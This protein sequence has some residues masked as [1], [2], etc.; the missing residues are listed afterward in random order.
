MDSSHKDLFEKI[1][2]K[3]FKSSIEPQL[4][5]SSIN[6][7]VIEITA[8]EIRQLIGLS[9]ILSSSNDKEDLKSAYE[10]ITR[11]IEISFEENRELYA[12][13]DIILARLGN[14]PGRT[15]LRNRY[16]L[17]SKPKISTWLK[18]E[19]LAREVENSIDDNE[20]ILT[21]F[22]YELYHAL[23]EEKS[24]SVS[25]PTSAG[26]SYILNLDLVRR[27]KRKGNQCIIYIVP[28]RALIT[29]VSLRIRKSLTSAQLTG[30]IVRT[31][32]FPVDMKQIENSV[33]YVLTQERL[34][35]LINTNSDNFTIDSLIVD[36]AHE[37]QKGKR[38]IVLQNAVDSV[39]NKFSSCSVLFA[40]PLIKNPSYFLDLFKRNESG[41][42][43][44]EELSPVSQNILLL[45][46]VPKKTQ[47]VK[48]EQLCDNQI[49]Q[50]GIRE[51]DFKFRGT[52]A[53]QHAEIAHSISNSTES[54]IIFANGPKKAED[55]AEHLTEIISFQGYDNA[56]KEFI[57]FLSSE[58][59]AEYPL[60]KCLKK[61][62]AFHYG[63]MPSI[64]RKGIEDLFKSGS[65]NY[66]CCTSTLL[67]GVNL[68]AKHIIIE[69]PHN[70]DT[71]M[72][73]ADFLNLAG[74]AGRLLEEFHGNIWCV[75]PSNWAEESYKGEK[76]SEIT[77]AMSV[78][79]EDGGSDI[80]DLLSNQLTD[81]GR[82]EN[83]E[84]AFAKLYNDY[85][86]G[87][88][89]T[90]KQP[91]ITDY[92][93]ENLNITLGLC[94][95]THINV[96]SEIL[97]AHR[98]LRPDHIQ[99]LLDNLA[100]RSS[101]EPLIPINPRV[102]G[103]KIIIEDIISIIND[104]FEWGIHDNYKPLLSYVAYNWVWEMPISKLMA[105]RVEFIRERDPDVSLSG[106]FRSTLKIIEKDI[107]FNLVKY[108]SVY[109]DVLK[110]LLAIN[111]KGELVDS[112]EP[113]HIY[114][115]FGSCSKVALNLMAIGLSRF[116]ALNLSR[117]FGFLFE[118]DVE[119]E[120]YLEELKVVDLDKARM[121][122][123]CIEE[124]KELVRYHY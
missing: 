114:F 45:S 92:D 97:E 6:N 35:S 81:K 104:S 60:I 9:S 65:V 121:P 122:H 84:A 117:E 105:D 3:L 37:I 32:P 52:A 71:P 49:I 78:I 83:A 86:L 87:D 69:D 74:R 8:S 107:R 123:L 40:S 99:K 111:D 29:E 50:L 98:S 70:G 72:K 103:A 88:P 62:V 21:D 5:G 17:E 46:D 33:V 12:A 95:D 73:R 112:V 80:Q 116:T 96:P 43:F 47:Q 76:L 1:K 7:E 85:V 25:A 58:I 63:D 10:I 61:G 16:S 68:P 67:Q 20:F 93:E 77:S 100:Q 31:A 2:L 115:E 44:I 54:T 14:F 24:L 53:K 34:I 124:V 30:V 102:A 48:V 119:P 41:R 57:N 101:L 39:L 94:E 113:L 23:E 19:S 11:L 56:L 106:I 89:D 38:G 64:V 4:P 108:F 27:L 28:T 18:L 55:I 22:Q 26:K 59:H 110:Y 118:D 51:V 15:L 66:I 120:Q 75:R 13:A 90:V 82:I 36:E 91:Y 42:Y 109:A 79:M